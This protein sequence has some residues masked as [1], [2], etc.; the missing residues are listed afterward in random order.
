MS[1]AFQVD[2][3]LIKISKKIAVLLMKLPSLLMAEKIEPKILLM[4]KAVV[5]RLIR[6]F[7]N[8]GGLFANYTYT[9]SCYIIAVQEVVALKEQKYHLYLSDDE[10]R[11]VI[12]TLVSLKNSLTTQ[13]RYT[14]G[15]DDVL[16][17][18][19]SAKKRKLKIKYI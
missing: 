12:Q 14:D 17:K 19:L 16:C 4:D 8:N 5:A 7:F 18:V 15:V 10:Y 9:I 3:L 11:Q 2:G 1:S 13:G 6:S